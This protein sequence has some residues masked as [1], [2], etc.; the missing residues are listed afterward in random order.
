MSQEKLELEEFDRKVD[1]LTE[2]GFQLYHVGD[3]GTMYFGL[4]EYRC[5]VDIKG[6]VFV[7]ET[8]MF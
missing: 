7:P 3:D 5:S 8:N 6:R 2:A 4:G 1:Q